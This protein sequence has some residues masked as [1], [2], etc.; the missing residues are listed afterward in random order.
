VADA[1]V[2][3]NYAGVD[4]RFVVLPVAFAEALC[5]YAADYWFRVPKRSGEVRNTSFPIYLP[6]ERV[7]RS[8]EHAA[9]NE[10]IQRNLLA[11]ENAWPILSDLADKLHD[12][13]H[14]PLLA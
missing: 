1:I 9:Q 4:S 8:E 2:A 12:A 13:D 7:T 6:F 3:V 10:R 5:R 14:W 11:F